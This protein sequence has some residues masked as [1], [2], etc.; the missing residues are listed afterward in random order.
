[1][2]PS[3]PK[4]FAL[5]LLL[6]AGSAP[7]AAQTQS[8]SAPVV[9]GVVT[10]SA[11]AHRQLPNTVNDVSM[12]IE[13]HAADVA[14][15]TAELAKLAQGLL[16]FLRAQQAEQV[17]TE[18][19]EISPETQTVHG[20]PDR[21]TGYTGRSTVT[22]RT[23]PDRMPALVSGSLDHG[24]N[25]VQ[26]TVAMPRRAEVSKARADL[27]SDAARDALAEAASVAGAVH[28]R[29]AGISEIDV[30]PPEGP[31]MPFRTMSLA[32]AAPG[33]MPI[34]AEPGTTDISVGVT[35]KVR[36]VPLD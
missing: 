23:T 28:E 8:S 3:R 7:V 1:M 26:R 30:Q 31:P 32:R 16:G 6:V 34:P 33:A 5:V 22:F 27:A 4:R 17:R 35:V 14:A 36:I 11:S 9:A 29:V 24:A 13:V 15:A 2:N 21:I 12:G 25:Q 19:I 10:T 20:Q 18:Q